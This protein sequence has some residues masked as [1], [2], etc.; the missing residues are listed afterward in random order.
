MIFNNKRN[1]KKVKRVLKSG[2]LNERGKR[3]LKFEKCVSY[4][5]AKYA[6]TTSSCGGALNIAT[7]ILNLKKY[8]AVICQANAFWVTIN[9]SSLKK[10]QFKVIPVDIDPKVPKYRPQKK[11]KRKLIKR[12]KQFYC[13]FC[14]EPR[15]WLR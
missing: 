14:L 15:I 3:C 6:I 7:K 8:G 2:I 5:G 4:I 12:Q 13:S 11:F 9:A 1:F 10:K